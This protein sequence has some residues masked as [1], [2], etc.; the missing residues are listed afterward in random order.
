M[1]QVVTLAFQF[2]FLFLKLVK[3][4]KLF[5][6]EGNLYAFRFSANDVSHFLL[7]D[8][9]FQGKA[10]IVISMTQPL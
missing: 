9:I 6:P 3:G 5:L 4:T 2:I 8:H 1:K 10:P 7:L